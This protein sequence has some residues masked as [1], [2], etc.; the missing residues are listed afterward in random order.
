VS[1]RVRDE[2]S[3]YISRDSQ[4]GYVAKDYGKRHFQIVYLQ[5]ITEQELCLYGMAYKQVQG[6]NVFI[7]KTDLGPFDFMCKMVKWEHA[8]IYP[9]NYMVITIQVVR[10]MLL[11]GKYSL[12]SWWVSAGYRGCVAD[13]VISYRRLY[14]NLRRYNEVDRTNVAMVMSRAT[15]ELKEG[16]GLLLVKVKK[17]STLCRLKEFIDVLTVLCDG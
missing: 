15:A 3:V 2:N 1:V 5:G 11:S 8:N 14:Y 17:C 12:S 16:I 4:I 9:Q 13:A 6:H 7:K 10:W